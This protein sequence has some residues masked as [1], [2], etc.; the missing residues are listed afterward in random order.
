[1]WPSVLWEYDETYR[2]RKTVKAENS[3]DLKQKQ[4]GMEEAND[5]KQ[6]KGMVTFKLIPIWATDWF[7]F[8]SVGSLGKEEKRSVIGLI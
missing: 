6:V 2:V 8:S 5:Q 1:M 3:K 7:L 4:E